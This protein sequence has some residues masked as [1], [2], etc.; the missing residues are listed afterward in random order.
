MSNYQLLSDVELLDLLRAGDHAV[1]TEIYHRYYYLIFFHAHKKLRDENE[2]K[3]MVQELFINL[4]EKR[5]SIPDVHHLAGYLITIIRNKM[6][7]RFAHQKVESKYISSIKDYVNSGHIGNTDYLV[8]EKEFQHYVDQAIMGL[9]QKMREVFELSRKSNL[10]YKEIAEKLT[11][12][13]RTVNNQ[14]SNALSRLKTKL[15]LLTSFIA[16]YI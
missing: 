6:F 14:I 16:L 10:T 8:R 2:A 11:I 12:S 1:Y 15:G 4:W 3:D 13:E 9:P 7:D 5:A